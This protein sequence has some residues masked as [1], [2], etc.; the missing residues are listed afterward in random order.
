MTWKQFF[1][2]SIGKKFVMGFTG[3]FLIL[4]LIIHAGINAL[5]F[6]NDHGEI[7]NNAAYF[8]SHNIIMKILEV[9]LF[10]GFA[11][12]IIQGFILWKQN[13]AARPIG[14]KMNR[15]STNS[16]WYSRSMGLLGTLVLL[17][18]V[19]HLYHFWWGTKEALYFENDAP[20]NLFAEMK[21]VFS[22]PVV[23]IL[24]MLGL[25]SL[26]FHLLHGFQS[27]FQTFGINHKRYTPVIK[28]LGVIYSFGICIL[29]AFMPI[30]IFLKWLD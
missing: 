15:P 19:M 22:N 9:G 7:Y 11:L 27:A 5:I 17:F 3:F 25:I 23:I 6:Y 8:L 13:S 16:K 30:A 14:Y 24:Y 10:A 29:F 21:E 28:K 2:S 1:T 18:L 12:H 20:H 26:L 4:Y